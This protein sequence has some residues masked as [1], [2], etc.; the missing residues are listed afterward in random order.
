MFLFRLETADEILQDNQWAG[1]E[2]ITSKFKV[3]EF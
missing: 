3:R 2:F 1:P